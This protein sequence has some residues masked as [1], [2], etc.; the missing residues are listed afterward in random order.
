MMKTPV[1]FKNVKHHTK[2]CGICAPDWKVGVTCYILR[3]F[4]TFLKKLF[5]VLFINCRYFSSKQ[6]VQLQDLP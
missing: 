4:V 5:V 3:N 1:K 6:T 2:F